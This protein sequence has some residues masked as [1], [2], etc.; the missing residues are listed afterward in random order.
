MAGDKTTRGLSNYEALCAKGQWITSLQGTFR[1]T[2]PAGDSFVSTKLMGIN[3]IGCSDGASLAGVDIS[4]FNSQAWATALAPAG[5]SGIVVSMFEDVGRNLNLHNFTVYA[6]NGSSQAFGVMPAPATLNNLRCPSGMRLS[7][8]HGQYYSS[9]GL[10]S[11]GAMCRSGRKVVIVR[12]G[13]RVLGVGQDLGIL[14]YAVGDATRCAMW[15]CWANLAPVNS[16]GE[17]VTGEVQQEWQ[18]NVQRPSNALFSFLSLQCRIDRCSSR[19]A[20]CLLCAAATFCRS[21]VS[22]DA[23]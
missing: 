23:S 3:T 6:A 2:S 21:C 19:S 13:P 8:I 16:S 1:S 7:G 12:G 4:V 5:F 20:C 10:T 9:Q 18:G 17:P 22:F 14:Q 11:M 15:A